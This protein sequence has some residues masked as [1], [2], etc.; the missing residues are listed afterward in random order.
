ME[1]LNVTISKCVYDDL[2]VE[3]VTRVHSFMLS[4]ECR[5]KIDSET[6]ESWKKMITYVSDSFMEVL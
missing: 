6:L 3:D 1:R 4:M 2:K 5:D